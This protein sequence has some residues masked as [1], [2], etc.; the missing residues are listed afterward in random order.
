MNY[1]PR[2]E[3][4][5]HH[6]CHVLGESK[7]SPMTD[8]ERHDIFSTV[9]SSAEY[10]KEGYDRIHELNYE[11]KFKELGIFMKKYPNA[12]VGDVQ[13]MMLLLQINGVTNIRNLMD[14]EMKNRYG[15]K[16]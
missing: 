15:S 14:E 4:K 7:G 8:K 2:V 6:L 13:H 3:S 16:L 9:R 11:G 5:A 12:K 10:F 1:D